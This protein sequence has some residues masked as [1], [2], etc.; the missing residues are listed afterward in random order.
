[1]Q[2]PDTPKWLVVGA[3][4]RDE[5]S[6]FGR[7]IYAP[8]Y[9]EAAYPWTI[10]PVGLAQSSNSSQVF[11]ATRYNGLH[12]VLRDACPDSWGQSI[13]RKTHGLP[14][15]AP[16]L[17]YLKAASNA[18]RWGALAVG[19]AAKPSIAALASLRLPT[20]GAVVKELQAMAA[21]KPAVNPT[22][23]ERLVQTPSLGGARPKATVQ[24]D[25][26]NYWLVKPLVL[27]DSANIP[28]LEHFA[29]A[30]GACIGMRF[31]KTHY[32]EEKNGQIAVRVLRF[33]RFKQQRKLCVS[34]A[35]LLQAEYPVQNLM[36]QKSSI[37]YSR[38]ATQLNFIGAPKNDLIELFERMVFNSVCGNDDD[39][40]RN[41]AACYEDTSNSW[42]LS[43]AFDVVPNPNFT[44]THL[45]IALSGEQTAISKD[46]VLNDAL[47]FGFET[48]DQASIHLKLFLE[49][50]RNSFSTVQDQLEKPL[51]LLMFKRMQEVLK[52]L[53]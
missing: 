45:A 38:L 32:H 4:W 3:Y 17:S 20:L 5:S 52:I 48:Y 21:F 41:H 7:F 22:L 1:M 16:M 28:M 33:D 47:L 30:W 15:D 24:D 29:Q 43:P 26:G 23:R 53:A 11:L 36:N 8:S 2:R 12:D 6:S 51:R 34:A 50:V 35:T 14:Q 49:N 31:A 9:V 40:I 39:H 44:P 19:S 27:N 18:D 13:L 37:S 46:A 42:R 25:K 10:D